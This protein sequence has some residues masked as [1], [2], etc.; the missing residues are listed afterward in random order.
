MI[1]LHARFKQGQKIVAT[2]VLLF[3]AKVKRALF[4][5]HFRL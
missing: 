3:G 5:K 2:L 1:F 4:K